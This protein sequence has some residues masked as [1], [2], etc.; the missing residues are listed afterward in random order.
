MTAPGFTRARLAH[1]LDAF[2]TA[3]QQRAYVEL[4]R[5]I[6]VP[7]V[8]QFFALQVAQRV[9]ELQRFVQAVLCTVEQT[10]VTFG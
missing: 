6:P 3:T 4:S 10:S 1:S 8:Y 5:S 2:L 7:S 9:P